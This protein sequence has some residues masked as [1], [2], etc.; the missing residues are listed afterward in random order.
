MSD[1]KN[2]FDYTGK[3]TR[4]DAFATKNGKQILTLVFEEPG[5]WPQWIAVKVFGRLAEQAA[6][7]KPG[8]VLDITGRLGGREYNGKIYPENV[9]ESV[10]VIAAGKGEAKGE[11]PPNLDDDPPPF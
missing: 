6:D 4:I 9:A 1:K 7:W 8:A 11:A 2:R 5:Q 3:L 10:E